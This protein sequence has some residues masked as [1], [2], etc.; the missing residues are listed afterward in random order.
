[1]T[2]NRGQKSKN[3]E[4]KRKHLIS[5][6]ASGLHTVLLSFLCVPEANM[7]EKIAS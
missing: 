1:M 5:D 2:G 4:D 3:H 6:Q 7:R